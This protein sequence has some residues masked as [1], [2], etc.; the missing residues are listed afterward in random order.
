MSYGYG[1]AADRKE[2]IKLIQAGKV[3]LTAGELQELRTALN[4]IE[5]AGDRYRAELAKRAGR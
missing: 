5:I 4:K 1:P 3:R 2:M